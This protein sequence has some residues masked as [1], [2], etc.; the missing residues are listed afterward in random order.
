MADLGISGALGIWVRG[1]GFDLFE[2]QADEHQFNRFLHVATVA[3]W[4]RE[5]KSLIGEPV[6]G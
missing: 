5:A 6:H 2:L 3:R 4:A 1:D